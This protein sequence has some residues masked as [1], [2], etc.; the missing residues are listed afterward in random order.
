MDLPPRLS[1]DYITKNAE[2]VR[3]EE[4][5]MQPLVEKV[6]CHFYVGHSVPNVFL[7]SY[8]TI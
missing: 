7:F 3:I 5:L 1:A 2:H 8:T 6:L 4:K